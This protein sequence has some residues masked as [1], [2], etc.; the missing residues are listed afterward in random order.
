MLTHTCMNPNNT[1]GACA[2]RSPRLRARASTHTHTFTHTHAHI[3]THAQGWQLQMQGVHLVAST[4]AG[5]CPHISSL[6]LMSC[7]LSQ[8]LLAVSGLGSRLTSLTINNC[9]SW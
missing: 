5:T 2:H 3:N 1:F 9:S 8:S 4:L 6:E 7:R